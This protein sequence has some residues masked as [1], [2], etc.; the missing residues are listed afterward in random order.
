M[1]TLGSE[2]VG[3]LSS[4]AGWNLGGFEGWCGG[5]RNL[6]CKEDRKGEFKLWF[7]PTKD[8]REIKRQY[9]STVFRTS[10]VNNTVPANSGDTDSIPGPGRFHMPQSS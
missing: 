7:D 9:L 2:E 3:S 10:L 1:K 6:Y 5:D 8:F 4:W